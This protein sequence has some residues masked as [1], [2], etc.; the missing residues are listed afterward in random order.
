MTV[1]RKVDYE[2]KVWAEPAGRRRVEE[3]TFASDRPAV[4][5]EIRMSDISPDTLHRASAIRPVAFGVAVVLGVAHLR[6]SD[7]VVQID[8]ETTGSAEY[9][10]A[11]CA[12]FE[13]SE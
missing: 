10:R 11:H 13:R 1:A 4:P 3:P 5:D 12:R 9:P 6:A 2:I 7:G 8:V